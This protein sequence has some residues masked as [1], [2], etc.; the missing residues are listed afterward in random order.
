MSDVKILN[1]EDTA[2]ENTKEPKPKQ[3]L[4]KTVAN[5]QVLYDEKNKLQLFSTNNEQGNPTTN[6]L[7]K[8]KCGHQRLAIDPYLYLYILR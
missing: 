1:Y 3:H 8:H 7:N 4:D 5:K 6:I 2:V